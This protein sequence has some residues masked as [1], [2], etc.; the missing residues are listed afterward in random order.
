MTWRELK[1]AVEQAG[2]HDDDEVFFVDLHMPDGDRVSVERS[3]LGLQI[4]STF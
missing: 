3:D 4:S 2:A 1:D